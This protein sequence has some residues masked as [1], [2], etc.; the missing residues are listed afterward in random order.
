MLKNKTI[1]ITGAGRG[2]GRAIALACARAGANLGINFRNNR[3]QAEALALELEADFNIST[4]LLHFDVTRPAEISA[5]IDPLITNAIQIDGWVNNAGIN[6]PGLLLTQDEQAIADQISVNLLGTI[7]CARY[8]LPHMLEKRAGTIVNMGSVAGEKVSPG[9][10]IYA[11]TKGAISSFT[12]A[13]ALE[14]GKKGIRVNCVA[15][16]PIDTDMFQH[17]KVLAGKEIEG[18]IP[19]QRFGQPEDV[20]ELVVFILSG[21][22]SFITGGVFTIDGGYSLG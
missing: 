4:Y 15:P 18:K 1:I 7:N 20:A 10:S 9:Q 14:Y 16:G 5:A 19:L 21:K 13:L 6:R 11:A 2:I 3:S 8:I 17:T 12:R 22:A